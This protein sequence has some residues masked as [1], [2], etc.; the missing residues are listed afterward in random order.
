MKG[1]AAREAAVGY[2]WRR[3]E[4]QFEIIGTGD[5]VNKDFE[6]G[7]FYQPLYFQQVTCHR[8]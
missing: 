4:S 2:L 7:V 8:K 6:V 3:E 1:Q 5:E